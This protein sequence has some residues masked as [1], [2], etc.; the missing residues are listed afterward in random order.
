M[1]TKLVYVL[2]CAPEATYIEQ[3][4]IS[5]FSARYH[6]PDAHIV[7]LVDDKTNQLLVGKRAELLEYIT[8]C[9][10]IQTPAEYNLMQTSRWLKTSVRNL[11]DGDFLF[12]DC[13]TIITGTLDEVDMF[14]CEIGAVVDSHRPV[15]ELFPQEQQDIYLF[16][17][18]C[19]W[20]FTDLEYYHNSGVFYVKDTPET[21]EFYKLWH[22][23]YLHS[24]Q[25]GV[26]IDQIS[27]EKTA[28]EMPIIQQI[29][30]VWNTIMFVRPNFIERAKIIHFTALSNNSFLF[31]KRVLIYI[32]YNTL[33]PYLKYHILH[34]M[35][36]YVPYMKKYYTGL[37]IW[38]TICNVAVGVKQYAKYIDSNLTDL[39]IPLRIEKVVKKL[40]L[41]QLYY[42]G[43]I[44]WMFWIHFRGKYN[45]L[46]WYYN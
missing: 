19:G 20:D 35:A 43:T 44:L 26:N 18:K 39:T 42:I 36:S 25:C 21:R 5:A 10:I 31:S 13:D 12:I 8:E 3:A 45:P 30:D 4:L 40:F 22:Q 28:Q 24:A 1:K 32:R 27:L 41:V 7:L 11:I 33:S 16:A 6:N 29:E 14:T 23:N 9:R 15:R 37:A 46:E 2:T 34:P 17:N 38:S